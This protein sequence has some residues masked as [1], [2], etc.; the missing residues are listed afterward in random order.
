MCQPVAEYLCSPEDNIYNVNFSR[1][2]IRDLSSGAVILDFKK[3]CPTGIARLY[4]LSLIQM[5]TVE[6]VLISD[7][8]YITQEQ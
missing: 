7:P 1:F 2:K 5:E 6:Q 3:H 8:H 4:L